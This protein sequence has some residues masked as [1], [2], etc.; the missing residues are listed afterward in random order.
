[1]SVEFAFFNQVGKPRAERR[2]VLIVDLREVT[3]NHNFGV[4]ADSLNNGFEL[5]LRQTLCFINNNISII[6]RAPSHKVQ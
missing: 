1:M 2:D 6:K 3:Q 4:C 5:E